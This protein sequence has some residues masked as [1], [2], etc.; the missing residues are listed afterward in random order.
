MTTIIDCMAVGKSFKGKSAVKDLSF[1]MKKGEVVALLGPNG[2]GKSTTIQMLLGLME[3]SVGRVTISGQNPKL[4]AV[5][6]RIGVMLQEVRLLDTVTVKEILQLVRGYYPRPLS[7]E[8]L[9]RLT[10]LDESS[11]NTRTE[12]LSGGQKQ[13]VSFA[14]ALAGNPDMLFLDEPTTGMD[15]IARKTFWKSIRELAERGTTIIFTTHYLDEVEVAATRVLMMNHGE[16]IEDAT[17]AMMK[18]KL[19]MQRISFLTDAVYRPETYQGLAATDIRIDGK[20]V[21]ILTGNADHSLK[22]LYALELEISEVT[23]NRGTLEE[24]YSQLTDSPEVS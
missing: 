8:Q 7:M 24:A 20:K 18:K 9:T 12:K 1:Q 17:P 15:A 16:L 14:L 2:A 13:R 22:I 5:R 23:V 19:G 6:E 4:K 10:G 21:T 3:P 11:L